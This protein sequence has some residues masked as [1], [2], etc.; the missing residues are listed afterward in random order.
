MATKKQQ[1]IRVPYG[2]SV[3]G[4]EEIDA[5]VSV[6]KGNTALGD[7]TKEFEA[8]VAK[9]FG[10]KYGVMVNS[11]S[12]ANLL[13]F[14]IL[15]LPKG[16][17]VITPVLTFA[18]TVAPIIQKGLVP[19]FVDVEPHTYLADLN[20]VEKA[21]TKKTRALMIPS[22]MGNIPNLKKLQALAKKHKLWLIE[23]SCD[24]LGGTLNGRPTGVYS[25]I[26]TTSFYGSHVINGAGG[27]GMIMVNNPEWV[28]R[29]VVLRGW[30][31]QSSLFGE[32]TNSELLTNRF[33]S[34]LNGIP[35][36]NKFIFSE[37][38]Y[39]FLPLEISSAFG[40]VQ[41]KKFSKFLS[42][43]RKN[44]ALMHKFAQKYTKY[45][46]LPKQTPHTETAWLAFPLIIKDGA[47]FTRLDI[48]T[49]LENYNVQT[50]PVFTGNVLKQPGFK[51]I[52][53]R[54]AQKSFPNTELIMRNAFVVG[55]HHGLSGQQIQYLQK[56]IKEFLAQ[57]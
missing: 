54:L 27:G 10:K 44:F 43:R 4:Q 36:D 45:F 13:A 55:S 21:I 30:G 52:P 24:T 22:L 9:M 11:G 35:Y 28:D 18:T 14:E 31:R 23:D 12:S 19:V 7:K 42:V 50:R 37:I 29:L 56:C 40:L 15:D 17:E 33:R 25:D 5:V 1:K 41:L 49:F 8:K 16:S 20:Q 38:G 6:L 34:K 46:Y 3:H 53:H 57:F 26:T 39:N 48:I 51:K 47:P 2:Y 32:K